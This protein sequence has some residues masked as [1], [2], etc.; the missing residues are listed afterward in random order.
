M[1]GAEALQPF[2]GAAAV[3]RQ[4]GVHR[5]GSAGEE[6]AGELP[7]AGIEPRPRG[8]GEFREARRFQPT[9]GEEAWRARGALGKNAK[10]ESENRRRR[11]LI[12]PYILGSLAVVRRLLHG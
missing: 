11:L 6:R 10:V 3:S 1:A 7:N 9:Q 8:A 5:D 2:G 12:M 4:V